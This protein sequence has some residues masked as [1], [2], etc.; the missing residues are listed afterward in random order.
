MPTI[1]TATIT[2]TAPTTTA[3]ASS[4][5]TAEMIYT[6]LL[7]RRTRA[8]G[9]LPTLPQTPEFSDDSHERRS[10]CYWW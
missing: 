3:A 9:E 2:I 7:Q 10:R 6:E 4:A 1:T 5:I 8:D